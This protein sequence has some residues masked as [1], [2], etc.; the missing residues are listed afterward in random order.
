MVEEIFI[1]NYKS[2]S[3]GNIKLSP[4]TVL[5]GVNSGGK[6]SFIQALLLGIST[7]KHRTNQGTLD[8]MHLSYGLKLFSFD[9]ILYKDALEEE[10]SIEIFFESEQS[11]VIF[12]P[13]DDKRA[14][15]EVKYTSYKGENVGNLGSVWY[16]GADR[17]LAEYQEKGTCQN[18]TIGDNLEYLAY[19]L[20]QGR[21]VK[22]PLDKKRNLRNEDNN[23][24]S[25]QVNEWLDYIMP[26]NHVA[27]YSE[28]KENIVSLLFGQNKQSHK[29][30]VG[31]GVSFTL[32]IL[33][34][35]L[36]AKFGDLLVVENPELH[37][38]PKAQSNMMYFFER[39]AECGVQVIIETHSDHVINGLRRTVV[40]N[41]CKLTH[42]DYLLYFFDA[43]TNWEV[44][45]LNGNADLDNWPKD[46][47]E[48]GEEDLYFIRKARK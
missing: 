19:I 14:D 43:N 4:I 28:G 25:Q 37:L 12:T 41:H 20:E 44:I 45:H 1:K 21:E 33:V 17:S 5:C 22:F 31:F 2:F 35:G 7:L 39:V 40:D 30:N 27:G 36:L 8:L 47:M 18:I 29:N 15:N 34:A 3:E 13:S 23:Y 9:E 46:F 24:F 26:G 6:S 16:L 11:K 38:H 32:P 42:E 10:I 48:Q